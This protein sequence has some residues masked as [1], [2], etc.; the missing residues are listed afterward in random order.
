MPYFVY[1][2]LESV[3]ISAAETKFLC[4]EVKR[5]D[6]PCREFEGMSTAKIKAAA[7]PSS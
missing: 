4:A 2:V 7:Q 5:D 1:Y 3:C 6:P